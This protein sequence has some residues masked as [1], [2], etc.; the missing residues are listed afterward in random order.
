MTT[1]RPSL[2]AMFYRKNKHINQAMSA[3]EHTQ[4]LTW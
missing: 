3:V 4:E 2:R 1:L